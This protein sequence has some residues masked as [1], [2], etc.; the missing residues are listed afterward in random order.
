MCAIFE[1]LPPGS[2]CG[3]STTAATPRKVNALLVL[4]KSGSM[5]EV[6]AGF[7][8]NK[9]TSL[10][11]ALG[12]VL[13]NTQK[14]MA[15]G[16]ELF[17]ANNVGGTCTT[18]CCQMPSTGYVDVA[19]PGGV[20]SIVDTLSTTLPGGG[21]PTAQALR[22]ALGYLT[23]GSGSALV[24]KKVVILATDG[25]P[26]CNQ[27]L[28]GCGIDV[29]TMNIDGKPAGCD[30]SYNCC[31]PSI[32][33]SAGLGCLDSAAAIA[34]IEEL[35]AAGIP[36]VVL[37]IPGTENYAAVMDAMALAG[38]MP[39]PNGGAHRYYAVNAAAGV[40]GLTQEI[41]EITAQLV[42]PCELPLDREPDDPDQ[43]AVA[44]DC[45]LL[46]R[47]IGDGGTGQWTLDNST[48]T[49]RL[50]GDTCTRV[51]EIGAER[52]DVL[53]GCVSSTP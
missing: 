34:A 52:L 14:L 37:G 18:D 31:D 46:T 21:T 25:G 13:T 53:Y 50:L 11:Q 16:L 48:W 12:T 9:W 51:Q 36:T 38:G 4:D 47:A 41:A 5:R 7:A 27:S 45:V 22:S 10:T 35:A 2:Y 49:V 40:T 43:V 42:N 30:A 19:I 29:C 17:P 32:G 8:Q 24:G 39:D 26:N 6:P 20:Q 44:L 1:N 15:Y 3:A 33:Q 23:L 28:T